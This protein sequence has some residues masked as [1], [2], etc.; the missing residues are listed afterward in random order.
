LP[1]VENC[2]ISL[3][4]Q[5]TT[6]KV[7]VETRSSGVFPL[8]V[9]LWSPDG[10]VRLVGHRLT[11]R[12]T[13]VSGVGIVL[14]VLAVLSLAVWWG[15]DLHHGRRARQLV[16]APVDEGTGDGSAG[17]GSAG[18][19]SAGG[20]DHDPSP[21]AGSPIPAA[22][23]GPAHFRARQPAGTRPAADRPVARHFRSPPEPPV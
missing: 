4:A 6:L 11:V 13:A 14:I 12:S 8:N 20:D 21:A 1:T 2:T 9:A 18:D 15:R 10:S 23:R 16:P 3:T 17:D 22:S 7:P 19:G 5:N